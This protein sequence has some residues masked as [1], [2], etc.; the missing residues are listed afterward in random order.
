VRGERGQLFKEW[1]TDLS[2]RERIELDD[3][4][5]KVMRRV[6]LSNPDVFQG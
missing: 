3:Q 1:L 2:D 6:V 4:L 5:R